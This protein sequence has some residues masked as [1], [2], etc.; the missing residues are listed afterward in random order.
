MINSSIATKI[1]SASN[2][3]VS[4]DNINQ[5]QQHLNCSNI[6]AQLLDKRGLKVE[7]VNAFLNPVLA[8]LSDPSNLKDL[9]RAVERIIQ[10]VKNNEKIA[11]YGDYDVDGVTGSFVL[12]ETFNI[13]KLPLIVHIPHRTRDGYGIQQATLEKLQAEGVS[14]VISVDCG[15]RAFEPLVWAKNNG[16]DIII[17]D[18]HQP[19]GDSLPDAY[20]L[21]NPHRN[22]CDAEMESLTGVGVAFKL[23]HALL[24]KS[25]Y[26]A[27]L[28][29]HLRSLL[30]FVALGM[31]ADM[32]SLVGEARALVKIGFNEI[33]RTKNFGLQALCDLCLDGAELSS[34]DVGFKLAPRINA[35]GRLGEAQLVLDL[36]NAQNPEEARSFAIELDAIN[37]ARRA[38][39][40]DVVKQAEAQAFEQI[41]K[42]GGEVPSFFVLSGQHWHRG[43][44]GI[45]A[46]RITNQFERPA[47]VFC[48][49]DGIL[50][51]SGRSFAK[52]PL[53]EALE[54]VAELFT[55]FGGHQMACGATLPVQNLAALRAG[56]ESFANSCDPEVYLDT[57]P[58]FELEI[59]SQHLS[60][61]LAQELKLLE[62]FGLNN[63]EPVFASTFEIDGAPRVLKEKHLKFA[64]TAKQQA[65]DIAALW[66][67]SAEEHQDTDWE[68]ADEVSANFKL[69]T[70]TWRGKTSIQLILNSLV[71]VA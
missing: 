23:A 53:L 70:N 3:T 39:Q 2:E 55:T 48:E 19:D 27:N 11:V 38:I 14:V 65:D 7:T 52:F 59:G 4:P 66:W 62:P 32:T 12:Q 20:A 68:E 40:D 43:V 47:L 17:T 37:D 8:D 18:H 60:L 35:A 21:I 30:P 22:D 1:Q 71:I 10:A 28:D 6:F 42:N 16:M 67:N 13:L 25:K 31:I 69:Q 49:E 9:D 33:Y 57:T 24:R 54:S 26:S 56:I 36:L 61:S 15:V 41:A 58:E 5:L 63:R 34:S 29:D 64:L 45:V 50:Y 46:A 44:V 51:G